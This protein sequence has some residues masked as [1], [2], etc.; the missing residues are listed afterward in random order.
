M[1]YW[2]FEVAPVVIVSWVGQLLCIR[3]VLRPQ[4]PVVRDA[5]LGQGVHRQLLKPYTL[6]PTGCA[7]QKVSKRLPVDQRLGDSEAWEV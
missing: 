7:L 3:A 6:D 5:V 2:Q 4:M 1:K